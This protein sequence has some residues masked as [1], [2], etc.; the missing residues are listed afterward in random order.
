MT[1][2]RNERLELVTRRL[3]EELIL[4]DDFFKACCKL[5]LG[6]EATKEYLSYRVCRE[7]LGH[8]NG[9]YLC[10]LYAQLY[11]SDCLLTAYGSLLSESLRNEFS[12]INRELLSQILLMSDQHDGPD[13]IRD[14]LYWFYSDY[15][16]LFVEIQASLL[17]ANAKLSFG[18]PFLIYPL[19]CNSTEWQQHIWDCGLYWGKRFEERFFQAVKKVFGEHSES[20][21]ETH[22]N[23]SKTV[24]DSNEWKV[25]FSRYVALFP[26]EVQFAA[27]INEGFILTSWQKEQWKQMSTQLR[28]MIH[29]AE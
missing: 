4:Q 8:K 22:T 2:E 12:C 3:E 5:A 11:A 29:M 26:K 7:K 23:T 21:N 10:L 6:K 25:A 28:H 27:P 19:D 1:S 24:F 15:C 13:Q 9:V 16:E 18:G 20:F 14:A 17:L